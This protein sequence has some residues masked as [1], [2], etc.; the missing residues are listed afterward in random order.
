MSPIKI[1]CRN[2][3]DPSSPLDGE[4][5]R[6]VNAAGPALNVLVGI[7]SQLDA[8]AAARVAAAT[9]LLDRG[10]GKPT[11]P[12]S[13]DDDGPIQIAQITRVIVDADRTDPNR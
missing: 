6:W 12:H 13:G 1:V 9:A 3:S 8:P 7:M 2:P 10:W 5:R 11:Q 4:L